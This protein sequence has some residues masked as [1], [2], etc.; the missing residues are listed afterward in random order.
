MSASDKE[1]LDGL[2]QYTEATEEQAGLMPAEDKAKLNKLK[3][4]P[5]DNVQIKDAVTGSIY[6]LTISNGEIK[7]EEGADNSNGSER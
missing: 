6:L 4:E 7:L 2:Q 5:V 1:K 3:E